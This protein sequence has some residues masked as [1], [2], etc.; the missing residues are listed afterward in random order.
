M[1]TLYVTE[2][3]KLAHDGRGLTVIVGL[4]PSTTQVQTIGGAS[5][6]VTLRTG[7]KFVRLHTDAICNI[8]FGS[9][10]VAADGNSMRLA[11]NQTE[12]FGISSGATTVAVIAGV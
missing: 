5:T 11:A 3:T 10:T 9:S 2:Y 6:P 12:F 8:A 1:S 7:S 4:E